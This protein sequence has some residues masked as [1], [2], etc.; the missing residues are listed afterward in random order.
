MAYDPSLG[1]SDGDVAK[2][3]VAASTTIAQGDMVCLNTSGFV[4]L[5]SGGTGEIF[6]GV[7]QEAGNNSAGA[8]GALSV[9]VAIGSFKLTER[10]VTGTGGSSVIADTDIGA[11]VYASSATALTV[12]AADGATEVGILVEKRTTT[13]GDVRVAGLGAGA[14]RAPEVV[15]IAEFSIPLLNI[16]DGNIATGISPGYAGRITA[17]EVQTTTVASTAAKQTTLNAEIDGTN[18]TGGT[19]NFSTQDVDTL[20]EIQTGSAPTAANTF[21]ASSVI[22]IEA[23]STTRFSEGE[24]TVR[25]KGIR[26]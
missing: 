17:I 10:T 6:L 25:L 12:V 26:L 16:V 14:Q 18:V 8:N 19:L 20:G 1:T 4:V 15:N 5:P 11:V 2:F 3:P 7:A 23:S 24:V 9:E 22:D 21:A 13:T